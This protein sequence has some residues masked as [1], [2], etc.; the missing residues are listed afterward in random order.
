MTARRPLCGSSLA[1][2]EE[3]LSELGEPRYRARQVHRHV[4]VRGETD[5]AGMTDLPADLRGRLAERTVPGVPE[6]TEV[7]GAADGSAKLVFRLADDLV[8]EGVLLPGD[9]PGQLSQ[10]LSTQVGCSLDCAFC[11]TGRL[12]LARNLTA[13]EIVGQVLAARPHLRPEHRVSRL[14]FMGMGEPLANEAALLSAIGLLT[15][16]DG[17]AWS[18]RRLTVSTAGLP[19]GITRLGRET[20]VGLAVSLNATT[21]EQRR[22]LM[23]RAVRLASLDDLLPACRSF[24]TG[25]HRRLTIEYVLLAGR[26]DHP[27]DARRLA[28]LLASFRHTR[29]NLIPFNPWAEA[30][31]DEPLRRPE[32]AAVR[33]FQQVLLDAGLPTSVRTSHGDDVLAACGQ[34]GGSIGPVGYSPQR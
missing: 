23:P 28:G 6:V 11:R 8:V 1:D 21:D 4:Y 33:A 2:L 30:G 34:L 19:A 15:D 9:H 17:L 27:D 26:N 3:L 10:C 20:D 5:P 24:P 22:S 16:P 13:G 12:G 31:P 29:V 14:V 7:H 25:S 18:P 32:E